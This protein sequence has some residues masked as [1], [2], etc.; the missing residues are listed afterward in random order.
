MKRTTLLTLAIA[1]LISFASFASD[2]IGKSQ[3]VKILPTKA[4]M[5]KILYVNSHEKKVNVKIIGQEGLVI[6]DKVKLTEDDNGFLRSYNLKQLEP[7]TYWIEIS[8]SSTAVKYQVTYQNNQIVWAKY[9]DGM[10]PADEG[11]ASN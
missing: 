3:S 2:P 1:T 9:W 6:K 8:D 11:L 5:V 7:G 4:G 10:M